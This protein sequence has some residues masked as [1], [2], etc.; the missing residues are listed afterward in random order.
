MGHVLCAKR[1]IQSGCR[2]N[3]K[4]I[5]GNTALHIAV[6]AENLEL[7]LLLVENRARIDEANKAEVTP[8]DMASAFIKYRL[9]E[10]AD[11]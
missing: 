4:N 1:L 9:D 8:Y 2:V 7:V 11:Q 10:E 3:N 6:G 5:D